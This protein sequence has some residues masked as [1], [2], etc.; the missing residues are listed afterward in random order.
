[1]KVIYVPELDILKILF[2]DAVADES[3]EREPG[4]ILDYDRQ[5]GLV[6]MEFL[7]ASKRLTIPKSVEFQIT[8]QVLR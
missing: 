1:M 8:H 7:D 5:G 4:M 6:G 2:S 3:N